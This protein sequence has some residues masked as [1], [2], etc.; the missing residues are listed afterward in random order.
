[1]AKETFPGIKIK[2]IAFPEGNLAIIDA[3]SGPAYHNVDFLINLAILNEYK[4]K[5]KTKLILKS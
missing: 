2:K 1:M 5:K 4:E 3:E